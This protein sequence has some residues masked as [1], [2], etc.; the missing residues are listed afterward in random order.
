MRFA[1][2]LST[3][4]SQ[5]PENP[6][7]KLLFLVRSIQLTFVYQNT[8]LPTPTQVLYYYVHDQNTSKY[9]VHVIMD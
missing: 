2:F 3:I 9:Y 5:L 1:L 7:S 4:W 6:A 8:T